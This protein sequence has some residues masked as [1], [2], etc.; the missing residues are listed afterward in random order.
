MSI[1]IRVFRGARCGGAPRNGE[2]GASGDGLRRPAPTGLTR[3]GDER[4]PPRP[5]CPRLRYP[6]VRCAQTHAAPPSPL[7]ACARRLAS[8]GDPRT[9]VASMVAEADDCGD[10]F[11]GLTAIILRHRILAAGSWEPAVALSGHSRGGRC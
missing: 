10:S 2:I 5:P 4:F 8:T 7:R 6:Q 3:G 9:G 11:A 1:M